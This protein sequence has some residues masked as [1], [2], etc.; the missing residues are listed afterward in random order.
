MMVVIILNDDEIL[1]CNNKVLPVDLAENVW[2]QDIGR[3]P[4]GVEAGFEEHE[5]VYP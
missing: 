2:L 3:R 4:C 5:P 1:V